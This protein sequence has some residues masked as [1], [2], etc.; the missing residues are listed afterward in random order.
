VD[1]LPAIVRAQDEPFGSTSMAA[2]WYVMQAARREGLTVML[3]GQGGDETLGGYRALVGF[4]LADLLAGLRLQSLARELRAFR[5]AIG[6]GNLAVALARPFAPDTLTRLIR[7]RTRGSAALVHADLHAATSRPHANGSPFG[8]RLRRH[9]HVLL[10]RRGLPE[11]LRYEDRNSMAH[12][13]EARVPF[14]DHRLV[15]LLFSLPADELIRGG[16][17]KSV[18]RR[19]LAD[20][21][22]PNVLARRDKLGFVTPTARFLRGALGDLAADVFASRAFADR[23]FVDPGAAQRRL[24]QHRAGKLEA[25]FELWRALNLELWAR[26]FLDA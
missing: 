4:H 14:L 24:A 9:Q 18:L 22:P 1:D 5:P 7:A 10:A 12:S 16:E 2:Q 26:E 20:L 19:A 6:A 21:L 11:L 13:L 23:G 17:T 15:E 25:G 8:D 3:D